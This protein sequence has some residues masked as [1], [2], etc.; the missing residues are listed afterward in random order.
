MRYIIICIYLHVVEQCYCSHPCLAFLVS[1]VS[2][3]RRCSNPLVVHSDVDGDGRRARG[4]NI[5]RELELGDGSED[6]GSG[7][8][9]GGEDFDGLLGDD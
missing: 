6:D 8:D 9:V 1:V 3:S 7:E 2:A 4:E 5:A